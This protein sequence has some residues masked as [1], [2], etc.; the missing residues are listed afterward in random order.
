MS[1]RKK[2]D[3]VSGWVVV[4]KPVGPT[5]TDVVTKIRRLYNAQKAGHAGTLDP[6]ASGI[7]PVA[8]G[9]ATK[10][11]PFILD[12]TKGYRFT[13]RFGIATASDD[14][15]GA[16]TATSDRRPDAAAIEAMLPRFTGEIS[17]VPPAFSAIKVDGERAYDLA[18]AGEAVELKARNIII[19]NIKLLG[20]P[21]GDHAELEISC[22]KGTYVRSLARDLALAL[23]T[24]G[25]VSALRRIA[26][27]PFGEAAAIP[28]DKLMGLG[29]IPPA[30]DA[31]RTH[32]LPLE[33]A[34]DDIPALALSSEDAS[35]LR[36]GQG[37][38]L[39]G[40]DA[41]I[42]SGPVL[43][44]HRGD[45]VALTEYSQGELKPVRVFNLGS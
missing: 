16:V 3:A 21:D 10:T 24:V 14:A 9:E 29:H 45:P 17:Q 11:V 39:R 35:R 36:Q 15:E 28:L 7:L 2:G 33:T 30:S 44:T 22:S 37:V 25:H 43:A 42:F 6:L 38:L 34:L 27:G 18:R 26:H 13:I 20:M 32:L 8:L 12:A 40:R 19:H 4:D 31:L 23:G 1:R 41:P 5:S